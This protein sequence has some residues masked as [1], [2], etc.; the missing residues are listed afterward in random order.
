MTKHE[1]KVVIKLGQITPAFAKLVLDCRSWFV[2]AVSKNLIEEKSWKI[3]DYVKLA[4]HFLSSHILAFS[5]SVEHNNLKI[6]SLRENGKTFYFKV[7]KYLLSP[8]L[9]K[10]DLGFNARNNGYLVIPFNIDKS[11]P[12][13]EMIDEMKRNAPNSYLTSRA[14][15]IKGLG[16]HQ[17]IFSHYLVQKE[18]KPGQAN[19]VK[20]SLQEIGPRM[21]LKLQKIEEGICSGEV[22]Y[23]TYIQKTPEE[24]KAREEALQ[25]KRALRLQRRSEQEENVRKKNPKRVKLSGD[26]EKDKNDSEGSEGS[27][28]SQSDSGSE[29]QS[30]W[31]SA[32]ENMP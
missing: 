15:V 18:E 17:Y 3:K 6:I 28:I 8:S 9:F 1:N 14:L 13:Y 20:L 4:K 21:E 2:P 23:H 24:L 31:S 12:I 19:L 26:K 22:L 16:D 10:K 7:C 25:A 30:D 5:Q 32:K 27:D 11:D 29:E